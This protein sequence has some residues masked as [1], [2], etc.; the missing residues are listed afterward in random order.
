MCEKVMHVLYSSSIVALYGI[1]TLQKKITHFIV[2][3]FLSFLG[4]DAFCG[5]FLPCSSLFS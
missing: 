3:S 1:P 2:I 5:L 4:V